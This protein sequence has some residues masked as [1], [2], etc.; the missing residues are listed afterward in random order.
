MCPSEDSDQLGHPPN[1]IRVFAVRMKKTWLPFERT[2]KTDQIPGPIG[3]VL[4]NDVHYVLVV[5]NPGP[6]G[7]GDIARV[8]CHVLTSASYPQCRGTTDMG[9]LTAKVIS[10]HCENRCV[11]CTPA[12]NHRKRV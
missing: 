12:H 2:A 9:L 6:T 4:N 7:A 3:A 5:C 10:Q 11:Q 8:R 1:L